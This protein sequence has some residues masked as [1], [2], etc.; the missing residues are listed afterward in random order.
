MKL[1]PEYLVGQVRGANRRLDRAIANFLPYTRYLYT[2][3]PPPPSRFQARR[4]ARCSEKKSNIAG[5]ALGLK[6]GLE[7]IFG[8]VRG[9]NRRLHRAIANLLP[10]TRYLYT[11]DPPLFAFSSATF[12]HMLGKEGK[13]RGSSLELE[14][15]ARIFWWAG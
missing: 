7:H 3:D 10:Y 1:G 9:A 4:S 15:G 8:Q 13:Y 12:R 6:L 14:I 5:R 2:F 11:F